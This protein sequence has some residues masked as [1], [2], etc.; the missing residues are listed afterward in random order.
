MTDSIVIIFRINIYY[1]YNI[2][3]FLYRQK[4]IN[5]HYMDAGAIGATGGF[6][7]ILVI[8]CCIVINDQ[9]KK[10]KNEINNKKIIQNKQL[11]V[12]KKHIPIREIIIA[13]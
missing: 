13:R 8:Y 6:G 4:N 5:T 7:I 3:Q 2:N 9:I 1:K 10:Y 11:V 12:I